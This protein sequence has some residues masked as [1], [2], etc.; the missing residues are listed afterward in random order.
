MQVNVAVNNLTGF[1]LMRL[2]PVRVLITLKLNQ[3]CLAELHL[4]TITFPKWSIQYTVKLV[5][6][7]A[8]SVTVVIQREYWQ[9]LP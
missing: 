4:T 9:L 3:I 5:N 8:L 2:K 7:F 1:S 6:S